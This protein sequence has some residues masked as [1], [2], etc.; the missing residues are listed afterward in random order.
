MASIQRNLDLYKEMSE[1]E[2]LTLEAEKQFCSE[3]FFEKYYIV[4]MENRW[5]LMKYKKVEVPGLDKQNKL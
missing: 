1:E 2:C 4:P 5:R 3:C